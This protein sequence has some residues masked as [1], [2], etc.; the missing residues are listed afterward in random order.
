MQEEVAKH[1][2][3][4]YQAV[5]KPGHTIL[6]KIKEIAVEIFIIVFAVTLSIWLHSWSDHRHEQKEVSEF[7]NG[8]KDDLRKDSGLLEA[9]KKS[10]IRL[11]S[12]FHALTALVESHAID[13]AADKTISHYLY[14]DLV[15]THAGIGRY[16]GFKSSGKI[17]MIEN[18]SLKQQILEY[19]EQTLP[20]LTSGE[21]YV[22][23][24]QLRILDSEIDKGDKT[25]LK[26]FVK[27]FKIRALL[28]LGTY[29]VEG[30][31]RDYDSTMKQAN[32]IIGLIDDNHRP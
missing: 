17:G 18:D 23:T 31:I 12:N 15:V 14:F 8:L 10:A 25:T 29:N 9:N 32:N 3:K 13:T 5:T 26:D 20:D 2:K 30:R 24:L 22:N 28:N 19:Y 4:I 1:T 27:S 16:E 11:D 21:N 6:G 7:L